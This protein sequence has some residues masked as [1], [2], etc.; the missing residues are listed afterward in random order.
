MQRNTEF[1]RSPVYHRGRSSGTA[2]WKRCTRTQNGGGHRDSTVS[3]HVQQPRR[4]PNP[5]LWGVY[6][7]FITQ[8]WLIRSLVTGDWLDLQPLF[9]PQRSGV[10]TRSSN[11]LVPWLAALTTSPILRCPQTGRWALGT[12]S[13][14]MTS[15]AG[16]S[17]GQ[18]HPSQTSF[19]LPDNHWGSDFPSHVQCLPL[20][21][22]LLACLPIYIPSMGNR[23]PK[24][25]NKQA[26]VNRSVKLPFTP[27]IS[28]ISK[29]TAFQGTLYKIPS[30]VF[31]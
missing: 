19:H 9:P 6:G 14:Q 11:P 31:S 23:D 27:E 17:P 8:V 3:P 10:G 2:T 28:I 15:L 1:T 18:C 13:R 16:S 25:K 26:E 22:S 12:T 5:V 29:S 30:C 21:R 20:C 24:W 7:G 4:P